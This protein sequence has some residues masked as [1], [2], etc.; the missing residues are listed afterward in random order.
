MDA[1]S[2]HIELIRLEGVEDF[3]DKVIKSKHLLWFPDYYREV[4]VPH[5]T[6]EFR[7]IL[8]QHLI[9]NNGKISKRITIVELLLYPSKIISFL[10]MF[11]KL[12]FL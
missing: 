4:N 10:A 12:L 8:K 3:I 11:A 7:I 2:Y 5:P 6:T 1:V 9:R